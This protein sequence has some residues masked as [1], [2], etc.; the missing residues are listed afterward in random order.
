[1][2]HPLLNPRFEVIARYMSLVHKSPMYFLYR[3]IRLDTGQPFYIGIGTCRRYG[4]EKSIFARAYSKS[5][6]HE[7]WQKI[8][9]EIGCA[10]EI[11]YMSNN[12]NEILDKESEFIKMHGR[13][14]LGTGPLINKTDGNYGN[15]GPSYLQALSLKH[16]G[17]VVSAET[18][19]KISKSSM[20][21]IMSE[22]QRLSLSKSKKGKRLPE[23]TLR[24]ASEN[25]KRSVAQYSKSMEFIKW[26]NFI[27][28]ASEALGIDRG[29]ITKC[30]KGR[31]KSAGGFKW[32]YMVY[33]D[34]EKYIN[35]INKEK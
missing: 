24:S 1:M 13:I 27:I 7:D 25:R 11:L 30:C 9:S 29:D 35:S 8:Y 18:R 17:R 4:T 21:K 26:W 14:D 3:H 34:Y 5:H 22:S 19:G 20:G 12:K 16:K 10:V 6:R 32:V 33:S 2:T 31:N 15:F 28:D 23:S